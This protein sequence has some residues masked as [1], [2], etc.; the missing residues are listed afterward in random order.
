MSSRYD[1]RDERHREFVALLA[2]CEPAIRRFVRSL[3]PSR[4]A[5]DDITQ[6]VALECWRK[7]EDFSPAGKESRVDEFL[8]WSCVI[9]R[10]KVLSHQRDRGRD[11]LVFRESVVEALAADSQDLVAKRER[12][13]GA[14]EKCLESLNRHQRRLLLSVHRP[15]DS[16]ADIARESGE[17][18][19]EL[20]TKLNRLRSTLFDCVEARLA[21]EGR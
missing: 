12:R 11:K 2:C 19:R 9:A 7:Y 13:L 1:D 5:V 3:L 14:V 20:Y 8:R 4:E 18:A 21:E 10:F 6:D 17:K 16:V 15:G